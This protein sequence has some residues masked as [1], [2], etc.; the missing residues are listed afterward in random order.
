MALRDEQQSIA[1][2]VHRAFGSSSPAAY[3]VLDSNLLG[4]VLSIEGTLNIVLSNSLVC[5]QWAISLKLYLDATLP[6]VWKHQSFGGQN[7]R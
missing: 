7:T 6:T 5:K 2:A 3:T 4:H 1:P